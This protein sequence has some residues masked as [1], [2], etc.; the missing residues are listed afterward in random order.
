MQS[1]GGMATAQAASERPA[2]I[3]ESGPASGVIGAAFLGRELGIANLLLGEAMYPEFIQG[4]ATPEALSVELRGTGVTATVSC[5]GATVT[6]FGKISGND[7]SRLFQM[8]AMNATDVAAHA[9]RAMMAGKTLAIPGLLNKL[10]VQMLRLGSRSM[11]RGVA[12]RLNQ[13]KTDLTI[14]RSPGS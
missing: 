5:P 3:I 4:A 9:Y 1:N 6:E 2:T 10:V 13:T 11:I 7:S 14:R 8:R 12:A